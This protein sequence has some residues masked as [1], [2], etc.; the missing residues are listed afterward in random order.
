M[1]RMYL[2]NLIMIVFMGSLTGE[3]KYKVYN[4]L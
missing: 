4:V 1:K 3:F 2:I